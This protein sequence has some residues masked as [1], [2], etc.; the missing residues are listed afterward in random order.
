MNIKSSL[1]RSGIFSRMLYL[2]PDA[3]LRL[4][5]KPKLT[6][7]VTNVCNLRCPLCPTASTMRRPRGF[8]SLENYKK[9]IDGV[10]GLKSYVEMDFAGEPTLNKHLIEMISYANSRGIKTMISTNMMMGHGF[11]FEG[12]VKSGL[13]YIVMA[14]DGASQET[15]NKYRVGADFRRVLKNMK[16]VTSARER[17]NSETPII[18]W[19]F[20]VMKHNQHEIVKAEKM[21]KEIGVDRLLFKSLSIIIGKDGKTGAS[22]IPHDRKKLSGNI[23]LPD[24]ERYTKNYRDENAAKKEVKVCSWLWDSVIL[25]NGD[26]TICCADYHGDAVVGNVFRDGGFKNVWKSRKYAMMRK[27]IIRREIPICRM[28]QRLIYTEN[29]GRLIELK[30]YRRLLPQSYF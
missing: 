7:E 6:I 5:K 18:T 14:V 15:E 24:D 20:I 29:T 13:T 26:V 3:V 22:F 16:A 2:M 4:K 23:D 28:C 17:L 10:V 12:L 19:Q 8:M 11:D 21:A 30:K 27:K 25:W 1:V 9:I